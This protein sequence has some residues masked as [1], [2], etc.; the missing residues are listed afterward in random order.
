[1]TNGAKMKYLEIFLKKMIRDIS[2][3]LHGGHIPRTT[4]VWRR[5]VTNFKLLLTSCN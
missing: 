1:V 2:I 4:E 3:F 5:E